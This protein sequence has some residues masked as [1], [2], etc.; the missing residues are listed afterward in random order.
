MALHYLRATAASDLDFDPNS[1]GGVRIAGLGALWQAVILG[2]AGLDLKGDMLGVDPR[3]PPQ[4]RSRTQVMSRWPYGGRATCESC[5]SL[6][7]RHLH[8]RGR[9]SAAQTFSWA[10]AC[11][12][13]PSGSIKVRTE[14]DTVTLIYRTRHLLAADW[15]A[16]E[17]RVPVTWTPCHFGGQRPWFVCAARVN[18]RYCGRRVAV[19]YLAGEVFA[20]RKCYALAYASQQGGLLFR[21]L[22]RSQSIRMRL[23]G[24]P[25]PFAP[26]P[27]KP[28]RMHQ[29]TYRRLRAQARAAEAITFGRH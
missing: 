21:N 17:Q 16:V 28:R 10:W 12:G 8:R 14:Q 7:V 3:L 22:R 18:G 5:K 23:G 20:C 9:L 27:A 25:D 19:L 2:F 24:S 4:W 26:F 29:R 15:K 6:D 11:A 13:E 1:A